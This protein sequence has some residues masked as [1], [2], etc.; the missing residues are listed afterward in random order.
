[1]WSFSCVEVPARVPAAVVRDSFFIVEGDTEEFD[2]FD[3][4]FLLSFDRG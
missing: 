4:D 2:K 3:M 1:V